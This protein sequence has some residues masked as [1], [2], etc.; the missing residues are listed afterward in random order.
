M[1]LTIFAFGS[2]DNPHTNLLAIISI[3]IVAITMFKVTGGIYDKSWIDTLEMSFLVNLGVLAAATS[4]SLISSINDHR[5]IA[6]YL[7]ISIALL[8]FIGIIVVHVYWRLKKLP[9][10]KERMEAFAKKIRGIKLIKSRKR[11]INEP[12]EL[13]ANKVTQSVAELTPVTDLREPLL[14]SQ[15]H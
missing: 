3:C 6:T 15:I 14:E 4:Y 10:V 1:L 13:E 2:G 11:I 12:V 5:A 7:S 8:T 9:M